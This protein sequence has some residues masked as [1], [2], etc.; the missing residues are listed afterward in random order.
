MQNYVKELKKVTQTLPENEEN[1]KL[2]KHNAE[3]NT[4]VQ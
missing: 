4:W 3:K 1:R 2:R